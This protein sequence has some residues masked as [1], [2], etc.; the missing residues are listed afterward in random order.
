MKICPICESHIFADEAIH[1]N[2]HYRGQ[3]VTLVDYD[4]WKNTNEKDR[5]KMFVVHTK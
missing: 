2:D 5:Y 1:C 3:P 4:E